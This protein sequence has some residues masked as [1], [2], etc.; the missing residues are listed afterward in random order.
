MPSLAFSIQIDTLSATPQEIHLI[1]TPE[2]RA[3]I[4]NRLDLMA[5]DHLEAHLHLK[6]KGKSIYLT[7][8]AAATVTQQCVR[9]LVPITQPLKIDIHEEFTL[10]PLEDP[11]EKAEFTS[12]D[13]AE[14]LLENTLDLGEVVVQLLSLSLDPYPVAPGSLPIDYK[15]E[16]SSSSPFAVL[17]KKK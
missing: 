11:K 16:N 5:L 10:S 7:G 1:A 6:K 9:T 17:K 15:E 13:L 14:P 3:D 2:E 12:E 8:K 4:A